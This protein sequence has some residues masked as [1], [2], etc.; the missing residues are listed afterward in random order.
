V[1]KIKITTT[2]NIEIE[3]EL[4]TIFDRMLAWL[5][6]FAILVVYYLIALAVT[7][8][9]SRG[10]FSRGLMA[11]VSLPALLYHPVIEWLTKGRSVGKMALGIRVVRIDGSPANLGNY[12]LRWIFRAIETSPI[13]FYGTIGVATVAFSPKGQRLGDMVAGTTVIRFNRKVRFT[14]TIFTATHEGYQPMFANVKRLDDQ[15]LATIK[16]VLVISRRERN[17]ALLNNCANRVCTVLEAVPPTGMGPEAFLTA[18]MR[19][20]NHIH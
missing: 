14:D 17:P 4:A 11:L 18:V 9:I 6:D 13:V 20:Y 7:A 8:I 19:D 5:L 16:E 12:L 1:S 15:D 3:Y 10:D 2:Q